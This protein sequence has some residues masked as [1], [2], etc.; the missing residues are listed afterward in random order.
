MRANQLIY[1][2]YL[3][4][5]LATYTRPS[6]LLGVLRGDL[7]PPV[8]RVTA[9]WHL[10]LLPEERPDRSKVYAANDSVDMKCEWT[11]WMPQVMEA[12]AMGDPDERIFPFEYGT[13]AKAFKVALRR[14]GLPDI[15]PYQARHSGPSIDAAKNLRDRAE[16]KARGR[17]V[18]EKSVSRY[19][20]RARLVMGYNRLP[21]LLQSHLR[22]CERQLPD[23][24]LG[25]ISAEALP[26]PRPG[27]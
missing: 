14:L 20:Q 25:N 8:N 13:F 19:E 7:Q 6:E 3:M 10:I 9:N 24:L 12:L 16:I 17:W 4:T 27:A 15:V 1:A 21:P 18:A 5:M 26:W 22:D 2:V 23:L 11:P